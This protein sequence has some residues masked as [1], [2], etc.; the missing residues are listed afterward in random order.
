MLLLPLSLP[1][2]QQLDNHLLHPLRRVG[3]REIFAENI[4]GQ[5][6]VTFFRFLLLG[7]DFEHRI[8]VQL[9][10]LAELFHSL[11]LR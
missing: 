8:I 7:H 1:I 4:A 9:T 10:G 5:R 6:D 11:C 2:L 3:A